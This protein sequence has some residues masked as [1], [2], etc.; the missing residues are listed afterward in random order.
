MALYQP[1]IMMLQPMGA[2]LRQMP[3]SEE[4]SVVSSDEL[5]ERVVPSPSIV[6]TK[7]INTIIVNPVVTATTESGNQ[8]KR[9]PITYIPWYKTYFFYALAIAWIIVF[10]Y[11]VYHHWLFPAGSNYE[12]A[13]NLIEKSHHALLPFIATPLAKHMAKHSGWS[14]EH[15]SSLHGESVDVDI[16]S[17]DNEKGN[18]LT[19]DGGGIE[20]WYARRH[21]TRHARHAYFYGTFGPSAFGGG[22]GGGGGKSQ[23]DKSS[24]TPKSPSSWF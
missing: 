16:R 2:L 6:E 9:K 12:L 11:L 7:A 20:D 15:H 17:S 3:K 24:P 14:Q 22:G 4:K 1:K 8:R 5:V 10:F 21:E 23:Q 18:S 13:N 19:N